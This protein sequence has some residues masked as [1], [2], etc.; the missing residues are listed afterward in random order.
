[1][2]YSQS[3]TYARRLCELCNRHIGSNN[4]TKHTASKEHRAAAKS[5]GV[6]PWASYAPSKD[7][8]G[9]DGR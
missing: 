4:W 1:M 6:E 9:R 2:G 8:S 5:A 3:V 7:G